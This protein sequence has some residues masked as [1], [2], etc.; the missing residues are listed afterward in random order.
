M[1]GTKTEADG[2]ILE[3]VTEADGEVRSEQMSQVTQQ[4]AYYD[5][6]PLGVLERGIYELG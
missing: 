2:S 6:P 4:F 5:T 1:Q 3:Y